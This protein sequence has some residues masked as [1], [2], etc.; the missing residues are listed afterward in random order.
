MTEI[1]VLDASAWV[2]LLLNDARG[3][4]VSLRMA[5]A[6][7]HSPAHIDLEMASALVE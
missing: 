5:D 7:L 2:D 6:A 3:E 4:R 1:V